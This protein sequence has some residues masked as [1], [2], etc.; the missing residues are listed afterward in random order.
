MKEGKRL[1]N[2]ERARKSG[3][4]L[5]PRL[6]DT[7]TIKTPRKK[8]QIVAKEGRPTI[9]FVDVGG[10]FLDVDDRLRRMAESERRTQFKQKKAATSGGRP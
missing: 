1:A 5:M 10:K 9:H 6:K 7:D 3:P 4:K 2:A 8:V